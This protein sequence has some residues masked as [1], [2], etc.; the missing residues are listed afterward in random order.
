MKEWKSILIIDD[1]FV[2]AWLTKKAIDSLKHPAK[3]HL[4]THGLEAL[5]FLK[6]ECFNLDPSDCGFCPAVIFL[7]LNMPV[8][9]GFEF[10]Q[11]F[12]TTYPS[13]AQK[14]TIY[15]LTSSENPADIK[16]AA[17]YQVAG[18]LTKPL[19]AEAVMPIL[20]A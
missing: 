15:V 18:F 11:A 20:K 4:A 13:F 2:S 19:K 3:I 12:T 14:L 8:M 17:L 9:D 5:D 7:D 1:D 16:K 6:E 10:L